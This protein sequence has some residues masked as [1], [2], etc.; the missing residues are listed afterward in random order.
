MT[1]E[2]ATTHRKGSTDPTQL[3]SL[4]ATSGV[5]DS[6]FQSQVVCDFVRASVASPPCSHLPLK[7]CF[8]ICEQIKAPGQSSLTKVGI[9]THTKLE[10]SSVSEAS[11]AQQHN[12]VNSSQ[13]ESDNEKNNGEHGKKKQMKEECDQTLSLT[14]T[15]QHQILTSEETSGSAVEDRQTTKNRL[16][17]DSETKQA[18]P[19]IVSD[20]KREQTETSAGETA[21]KKRRMGMC[22]LKEKEQS[23]FLQIKNG[24]SGQEQAEGPKCVFTADTE[25]SFLLASSTPANIPQTK[26][27]EVQASSDRPEAEVRISC[28]PDGSETLCKPSCLEDK[29]QKQDLV[30]GPD[31]TEASQ[32]EPPEEEKQHFDHAK[33][34]GAVCVS[35]TNWDVDV[36]TATYDKRNETC[37]DSS[38]TQLSSA[39]S[40]QVCVEVCEATPSGASGQNDMCDFYHQAADVNKRNTANTNTHLLEREDYHF[41]SDTQLNNISF[42][43]DEAA[44]E[45]EDECSEDATQLVC[46]L[47][48]ELSFLNRTVMA[49][50]RELENMRRSRKNYRKLPR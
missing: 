22:G 40:H 47:I 25:P 48:K 39:D 46:G 38:K 34:Q 13:L 28:I 19:S 17:G 16:Q 8:I 12:T 26:E 31:S 18:A 5:V 49:A 10:Q 7:E 50:H 1:E 36:A 32:S 3:F 45:G 44:K 24:H 33:P 35:S 9:I 14:C 41:V 37:A 6:S 20:S 4:E 2:S 30:P 43:Q 11:E 21:K 42:I 27:E 29:D 23:P 15:D